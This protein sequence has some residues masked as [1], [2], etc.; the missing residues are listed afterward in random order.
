MIEVRHMTFRYAEAPILEDFSLTLPDR[1]LT[2]LS[3]PSGCGKTTLLRLLAGLERPDSGTITGG[4]GAVPLF[5]ENRL[6][7]WRTAEQHL[8]DVLPRPRWAEAER[9]LALVELEGEGDKYPHQLSGGMARRLALARCLACGGSLLLLDEPFAGVDPARRGRILPRLRALDTPIIM[10]SHEE[11]ARAAAD[12]VYTLSGP[13]LRASV[14]GGCSINQQ[15][16]R[17]IL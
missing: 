16:E 2:V 4:E 1:G 11:D 17:E 9:W 15:Q 6:F 10:T 13:P 14:T 5:Q 8:R 12:A 3:G 7:P